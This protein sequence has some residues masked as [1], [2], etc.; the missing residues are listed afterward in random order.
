MSVALYLT[1]AQEL[2]HG[3]N[4]FASPNGGRLA[5]HRRDRRVHADDTRLE[6][7]QHLAGA[8][9]DVYVHSCS[10]ARQHEPAAHELGD[11]TEPDDQSGSD[12]A[13]G[14]GSS[15]PE[16]TLDESDRYGHAV[17]RYELDEG[18]DALTR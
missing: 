13:T 1:V 8:K 3:P 6:R 4:S 11:A 5:R 17:D 15:E 2:A 10:T 9:R 18:E 12:G 16:R 14:V 7:P